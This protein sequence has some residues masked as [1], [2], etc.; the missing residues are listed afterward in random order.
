[1]ANDMNEI[2]QTI[3]TARY[4]RDMRKA[5]ADGLAMASTGGSGILLEP[6]T[7][8]AYDEMETHD[9]NTLYIIV[10]PEE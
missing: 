9:E 6:T 4:G 1:M 10:E 3:R 8:E 2:I 5:I 7:Q